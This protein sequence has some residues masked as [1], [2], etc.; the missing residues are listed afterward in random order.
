MLRGEGCEEGESGDRMLCPL[1]GTFPSLGPGYG[2]LQ[3]EADI[4]YTGQ[5]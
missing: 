2:H 1:R 5:D 4:V 3:S